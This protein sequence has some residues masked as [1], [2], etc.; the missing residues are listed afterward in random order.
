MKLKQLE[1]ELQPLKGFSAPK[2][3]YEQYV[4]PPHL[5]SRMI[6]TAESSF[7]DIDDKDCL[8]LGCGCAVLSIACVMLGASSVLSVDAD[9]AALSIARENIASLEME[10]EIKLIH[11]RI[12]VVGSLGNS[13]TK[14]EEEAIPVF[15]GLGLDRT[16][17]TVVMNPPF[18]TWNQGIDMVFLEAA[19]KLAG[20]AVY[21]LHKTSTRDFLKKKAVSLGFNGEVLAEMKYALPKTMPF[22]KSKSVDIQVDF[23]RFER[24]VPMSST[25]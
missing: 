24:K 23:W 14:V 13:T 7:G 15:V 16:F 21:S 18:G 2:R 4:T 9:E 8:D 12:G 3:E 25:T 6:F 1:A 19:C 20:T 5:A 22:H 11:A 10:E 17:D